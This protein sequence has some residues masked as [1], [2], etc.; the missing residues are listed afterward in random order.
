MSVVAASRSE[1]TKVFTTSSWWI[2]AIVLA[3]YVGSLAGGMAWLFGALATG[4]LTG[5]TAGAP[6]IEASTL[7]LT[8]F[9]I[10]SSV[11]YVF[12]LLVGTLMVPSLPRVTS[13]P[14][15]TVT[16]PPSPITGRPPTVMAPVPS[17]CKS[18]R[19]V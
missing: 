18:P 3:L 9:S 12:P 2:L 1:T 7:P 4:Q 10:A 17:T 16:G 14:S 15:G 19:R 8:M 5:E 11:G 13:L 6:P